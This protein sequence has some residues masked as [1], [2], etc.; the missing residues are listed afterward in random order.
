MTKEHQPPQPVCRY[1]ACF[2]RQVVRR[3]ANLRASAADNHSAC[4]RCRN[5]RKQPHAHL[6]QHPESGNGLKYFIGFVSCRDDVTWK[7][8][9]YWVRRTA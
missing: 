5:P 9:R 2:G 3:K 7:Q 1:D 4:G 6:I 8:L